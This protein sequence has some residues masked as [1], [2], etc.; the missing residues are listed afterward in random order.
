VEAPAPTDEELQASLRRIIAWLMKL[1]TRR[2]VL[3]EEQATYLANCDSD[4]DEARML[5]PP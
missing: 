1:L 2:A 3:V 4:F 5:G